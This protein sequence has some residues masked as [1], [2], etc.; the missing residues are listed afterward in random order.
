MKRELRLLLLGYGNVARAFLPL[1]ASR[2][3]WMEQELNIYPLVC[4]IGSRR[5]GFFIHPTG[6][7]AERFSSQADL[8]QIL[9][10]E[11]KLWN[12]AHSFIQAGYAAGADVLVELTTMNPADGEPA[13]TYI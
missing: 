8:L 3:A 1:L 6:I 4:G 9:S 2:S 5:S 10:P 13:L 12:D 11:S 7:P